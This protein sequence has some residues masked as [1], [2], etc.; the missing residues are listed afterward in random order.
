M[1]DKSI[2]LIED[3]ADIATM[4]Q[5]K[6]SNE[7]FKI[8]HKS[9]GKSGWEELKKHR[10]DLLLLDIVLP[11]KDGFDILKEVRAH[12]DL[13]DL[14]VILLTNLGQ[15]NDVEQGKKLKADAYIIKARITPTELVDEINTILQT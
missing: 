12:P 14:K 11:Q 1:A 3:D 13:H 2:L 6:L 8:T 4:Y 9:D 15:K 5:Q 7:G 10:P